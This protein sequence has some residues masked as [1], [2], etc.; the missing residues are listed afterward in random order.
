[1][2]GPAQP[3]VEW[4]EV[5]AAAT[6]HVTNLA[7]ATANCQFTPGALPNPT[8][9]N[10]GIPNGSYFLLTDQNDPNQN[11]VWLADAN[12]PVPIMTFGLGNVNPEANIQVGPGNPGSQNGGS[13]WTYTA[14]FRGTGN[15]PGF[16]KIR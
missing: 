16:Q 13:L 3:Q 15:T 8:I 10:V 1:M 9:D 4:Y 6:T 7:N 14:Q 12:G 5:S 2:P 11:G